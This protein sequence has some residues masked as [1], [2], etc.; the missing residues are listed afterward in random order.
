MSERRVFAA[1]V[2]VADKMYVLGGFSDRFGT[3]LS[4]VESTTTDSGGVWTTEGAMTMPEVRQKHCAVRVPQTGII[5][6]AG[7]ISY[8]SAMVYDTEQVY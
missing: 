5:F 1:A 4:S 2:A 6:V 3:E 8:S 7:G